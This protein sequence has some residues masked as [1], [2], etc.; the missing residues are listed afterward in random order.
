ML[1]LLF[2]NLRR[3]PR[4]IR[5]LKKEMIS[6]QIDVV[7]A[8]ECPDSPEEVAQALSGPEREF[9]LHS[10]KLNRR[11]NVFAANT[12]EVKGPVAESRYLVAHRLK[13]PD[14]PEIL[15]ASMHGISRLEDELIDLDEEAGIA[16]ELLR[17]AEKQV[18]H[19]RTLLVGD[20][21]LNPF[22]QG[23]AKVRGF[24]GVMSRSVA[25]RET[26][27]LKS[28][29]YALFYNPMWSRLGDHSEGPPGTYYR[30]KTSHL[31]YYWHCYDQMLIRPALIPC[32]EP[33][34]L[35]VLTRLAGVELMSDGKP[36]AKN[37]SDHLPVFVVLDIRKAKVHDGKVIQ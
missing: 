18:R 37:F 21:N 16:A 15:L 26:Q 25:E 8:T 6:R 17:A 29:D 10:G 24:Y 30:A 31:S 1:R 2:W 11:V 22:D 3:N 5:L 35:S 13:I 28:K 34:G 14:S 36:D 20:F 27:R 23:M 4:L 19:Q 33:A 12:V 9:R 32:F 7:V